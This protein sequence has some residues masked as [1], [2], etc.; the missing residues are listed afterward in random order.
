MEKGDNKYTM[1]CTCTLFVIIP[2]YNAVKY[3]QRT[4]QSVI[5]QPYNNIEIILINDGSVDGSGEL[6]DQIAKENNKITVI[7]QKNS[8]V[9]AARNNGLRYVLNL[10]KKSYIVFLDS[11]DAWCKNIFDEDAIRLLSMG[12]D[13]IGMQSANCNA[14]L[15]K[16][17]SLHM[18]DEGEHR[19]GKEAVYLHARQHFAAMLYSSELIQK[20]GI[21][22]HEEI[23]YT[24]DKLFQM[25]CM[26]VAN[27][28]Y[29][30]NKL[31]YLYRCNEK[32]LIHTRAYGVAYFMHIIN[33][34][35][36]L[37]KDMAP[38]ENESRG[39]LLEGKKLANIYIMD[40]IDE[41]FMHLGSKSEV[42]EVLQANPEWC[43]LVKGMVEDIPVNKK[44]LKLCKNPTRYANCMYIKGVVSMALRQLFKFAPIEK[45]LSAYR[46]RLDVKDE[47]AKGTG[48]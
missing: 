29:L 17:K 14:D 40:M 30:K 21:A 41:H 22:F 8:G 7:H 42:F 16:M 3:L 27:S 6:C 47:F 2:V 18:L 33:A 38:Y 45:I 37:D 12:Y 24:E 9:S 5:E 10:R 35:L 19:G 11:D 36:A 26:Y 43:K 13:L 28:I 34:Y 1:D 25:S 4:V 46:Y 39:K 23:S 48:K 44:Y 32:S 15:T 20:Y 31:M